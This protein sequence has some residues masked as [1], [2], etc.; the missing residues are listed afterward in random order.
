MF[1][2]KKLSVFVGGFLLSVL[3]TEILL[4]IFWMPSYLNPRFE[5]DDL[6]WISGNVILNR[7]GYRD[8]EFD[9]TN[10]QKYRIYSLGD[11]YTYGWYINDLTKTYPKLI[12]KKLEDKYGQGIEVIN[13]SRPGFN[14]KESVIRFKQEGILFSPDLVT[15]GINIFDITDN[16]LSSNLL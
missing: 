4:K 9:L 16:F 7:F 5:R 1:I 15:L 11:S 14:L 13:A 3:I 12:E 8:R 6:K 10:R 2:L